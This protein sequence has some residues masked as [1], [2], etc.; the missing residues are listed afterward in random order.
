MRQCAAGEHDRKGRTGNGQ[1]MDEEPKDRLFEVEGERGRLV[2]EL[3][4]RPSIEHAAANQLRHGSQL[5]RR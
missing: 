3:L 5:G 2:R 1:V 4:A